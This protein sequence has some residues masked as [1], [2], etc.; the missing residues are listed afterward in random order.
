MKCDSNHEKFMCI[1]SCVTKSIEILAN[2][3][4][5]YSFDCY[6]SQEMHQVSFQVELQLRI[7]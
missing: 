1:F 7:H 3:I 4:E 2:S 6:S 5:L